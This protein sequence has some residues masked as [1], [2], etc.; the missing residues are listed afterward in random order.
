MAPQL[1][2]ML[3]KWE[4]LSSG[5]QT[6]YKCQVGMMTSLSPSL[7]RL[8]LDILGKLARKTSYTCELWSELNGS[9]SKNK[10]EKQSR[11]IPNISLG[12]HLR[13]LAYSHSPTTGEY[14][15]THKHTTPTHIWNGE[16]KRNIRG[17]WTGVE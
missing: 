8:R 5:A 17:G 3:C 13:L 2:C 11:N 10:V 1:K 14:S 7:G 12:L 16:K 4:D 15:C 9:I 6:P